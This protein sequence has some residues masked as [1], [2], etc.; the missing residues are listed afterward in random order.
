MRLESALRESFAAVHRRAGLIFVD[1]VWKLIWLA[2]TLAALAAV[3]AWFASRLQAAGWQDT[4]IPAANAWVAA[5]LLREFWKANRREVFLVLAGISV[6]SGFVW[7]FLEAFFRSRLVGRSNTEL[8]LFSGTV[9]TSI[10]AAAAVILVPV[11]LS[12]ALGLAVLLFAMLMFLTTLG[13]T[14]FR[15]EA[16]ELIATDLLAVTGLVAVLL[17][18][19][20]MIGAS[21]GV[22]LLTG[23]LKVAGW[24]GVVAMV[25]AAAAAVVFLNLLH[26]YLL[27]V[28]FSAVGIMRRNLLEV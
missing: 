6:M 16:V 10:L 20:T 23:F 2:V 28:R 18:F 9:K 21:V 5:A 4:G 17:L 25:G 15:S 19:E 22:I 11:W 24:R 14:L 3:A 13:E 8:F 26:S 12:G 1:V 27:L 7:I